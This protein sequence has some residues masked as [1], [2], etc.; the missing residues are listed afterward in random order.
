MTDDMKREEEHLT[1]EDRKVLG[2][3]WTP[4]AVTIRMAK[5]IA[6]ARRE[7]FAEALAKYEEPLNDGSFCAGD[8]AV[9]PYVSA[10]DPYGEW[11]KAKVQ[12]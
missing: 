7:A 2:E 4:G 12:E 11:L 9:L 1:P 6:E 8:G 10:D 3:M 5:A